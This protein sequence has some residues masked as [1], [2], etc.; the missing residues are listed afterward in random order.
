MKGGSAVGLDA[1]RPTGPLWRPGCAPSRLTA[2]QV[3]VW[4]TSLEPGATD[5]ALWAEVLSTDERSRADRF[6]FDRD[7]NRF[8]TARSVLRHI[9]GQYLDAAP[10]TIQFRYG[11]HGKPELGGRHERVDLRFNA[12]H[13]N[14][15]A[16]FAVAL[17]RR[18][19]VDV[20]HIR[21][22][23]D[24]LDL[25][26]RFLA[27]AEA[28]AIVATHP[29]QQ[30]DAFFRCWTR[31]EAYLKAV[32]AGLGSPLDGFEVSVDAARPVR[33]LT[34]D[35]S[36]E[37]AARWNLHDVPPASDYAAAVAFDGNDCEVTCWRFDARGAGDRTA[38]E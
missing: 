37:R 19:G 32:G 12:S 9:L 27:P 4:R 10:G 24:A 13:S 7:R 18:V 34:I 11:F 20:E 28:S 14:D 15:V 21:P 29:E 25:A 17:G 2:D 36:G 1:A 5:T 38:Q 31:K 35:G 26:R 22:M 3:H 33:L 6:I 23:R 8:R 16:L 30:Q